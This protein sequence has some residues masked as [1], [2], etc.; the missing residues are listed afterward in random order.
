[1]FLELVKK[2]RSY[3][4][5]YEEEAISQDT[6]LTL[7]NYARLAPSGGNRQALQY[8]LSCD[9]KLNEEIYQTLVWAMYL[10]DW[11]GPEPGERPAAY[12]VITQDEGYKM[13]A[14]ID[15]GIAAQT[16]VLGATEMGLGGCMFANIKKDQLRAVLNMPASKEILLVIALGKPKEIVVIDEIEADGDIKYWREPNGVHHVPKRKLKDIVMNA[17]VFA[18]K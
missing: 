8:Y 12:I 16:I 11:D 5:F 15:Y 13:A 3:R 18:G 7:V 4:R 14:G 10:K 6:L 9:R 17:D 1:M 2:N